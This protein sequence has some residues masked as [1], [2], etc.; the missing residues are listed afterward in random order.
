[1][2]FVYAKFMLEIIKS[3]ESRRELRLDCK[4]EIR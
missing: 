2:A 4:S 3:N 1:M